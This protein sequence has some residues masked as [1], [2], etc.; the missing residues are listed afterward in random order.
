[1]ESSLFFTS[2]GFCVSMVLYREWPSWR[3][4]TGVLELLSRRGCPTLRPLHSP[5]RWRWLTVAMETSRR[6]WWNSSSEGN[7]S[8]DLPAKGRWR[9]KPAGSSFLGSFQKRF[10]RFFNIVKE[11]SDG[12][13]RFI[14]KQTNKQIVYQ[15]YRLPNGPVFSADGKGCSR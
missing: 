11:P 2:I 8:Q 1:M 13:G 5:G 6:K 4:G 7:Q 10:F 12:S 14:R 3:H 15:I 9:M